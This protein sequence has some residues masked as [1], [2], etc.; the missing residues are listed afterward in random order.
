MNDKIIVKDWDYKVHEVNPWQDIS[1]IPTTGLPVQLARY[2]G[3]ELRY[4]AVGKYYGQSRYMGEPCN[5]LQIFQEGQE[6]N[7]WCLEF[8]FTHWKRLPKPPIQAEVN[9]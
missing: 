5:R 6:E 2:L 9:K 3:D 1:S 4:L 7:Y 8:H